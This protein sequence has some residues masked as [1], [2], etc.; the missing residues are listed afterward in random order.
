VQALRSPPFKSSQCLGVTLAIEHEQP[1]VGPTNAVCVTKNQQ[2]ARFWK[3][4][5]ARG[6]FQTD[7]DSF[8]LPLGQGE[9]G[10]LM[11]AAGLEKS[12]LIGHSFGSLIALEAR[13]NILQVLPWT[14]R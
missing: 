6:A 8:P 2:I 4:N 11:D 14:L 13:Q 1:I 12:V 10:S 9:G 3:P 7:G 5:P